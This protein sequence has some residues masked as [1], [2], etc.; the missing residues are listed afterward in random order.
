MFLKVRSLLRASNV[1]DF[2]NSRQILNSFNF[3]NFDRK[4]YKLQL[5][6]WSVD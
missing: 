3:Y 6:K 4:K 2:A 5:S 1:I